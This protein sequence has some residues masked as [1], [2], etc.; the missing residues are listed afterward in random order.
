MKDIYLKLKQ[1]FEVETTFEKT[2]ELPSC[3]KTVVSKE[4]PVDPCATKH[5][6]PPSKVLEGILVVVSEFET[7]K[8]GSKYVLDFTKRKRISQDMYKYTKRES[9]ER[10][11]GGN[12]AYLLEVKMAILLEQ[13]L[14]GVPQS[15]AR[16]SSLTWMLQNPI[17]RPR[18]KI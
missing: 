15:W 8:F 4:K 16:G 7:P 3:A 11:P 17:F 5:I 12:K 1:K 18:S 14:Q 9:K 6:D 10:R 13:M 2:G